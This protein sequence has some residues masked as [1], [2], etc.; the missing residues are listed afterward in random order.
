MRSLPMVRKSL[1]AGF[2][3]ALSMSMPAFA[4]YLST[5]PPDRSAPVPAPAQPPGAVRSDSLTITAKNGQS[6]QQQWADRYECHKWAKDQS[7][8]DPTLRPPSEL[9][10]AEVNSRRD[11]YR[12][13]FTAFLEGRCYGVEYGQ[14]ALT[15]VEIEA[16]AAPTTYSTLVLFDAEVAYSTNDR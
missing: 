8:F 7:G 1:R 16:V 4:Q 10:G 3:V 5:P 15:V 2:F 14:P 13:G 12:R 9:S 6:D 11:Q